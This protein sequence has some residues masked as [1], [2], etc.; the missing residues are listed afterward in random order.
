MK[1]TTIY[2]IYEVSKLD[3]S[4]VNIR[5]EFSPSIRKNELS[6][7]DTDLFYYFSINSENNII[8]HKYCTCLTD[9]IRFLV[10]KILTIHKN[11]RIYNEKLSEMYN[12]YYNIT[13]NYQANK[14]FKHILENFYTIT[15]KQ[16]YISLYKRERLNFIKNN[17]KVNIQYD[18]K[19]TI[20]SEEGGCVSFECIQESSMDRISRKYHLIKSKE[21]KSIPREKERLSRNKELVYND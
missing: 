4:K 18:K 9:E 10:N 2:Y 6:A 12:Y 5:K 14:P 21:T 1:K 17:K 8:N 7:R 15:K 3:I 19:Q 20:V 13:T 11:K 16:Y